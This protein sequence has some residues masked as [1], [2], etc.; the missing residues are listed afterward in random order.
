MPNPLGPLYSFQFLAL[1][2]CAALY[3]KLASLDPEASSIVW[4]VL[5][6]CT[7]FATWLFLRWGWPGDLFGQVALFAGI[8]AVRVWRDRPH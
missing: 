3:A 8:T 1:L 5:S 4:A 6:A 7:F 2:I